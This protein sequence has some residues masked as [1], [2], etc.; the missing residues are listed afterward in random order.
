MICPSCQGEIKEGDDVLSIQE[1]L[2]GSRGFVAYQ[3]ALIFCS[4]SC[5]LTYFNNGNRTGERVP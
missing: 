1:G 5:L 4:K 2:L 3:E